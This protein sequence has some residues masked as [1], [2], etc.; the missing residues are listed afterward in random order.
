MQLVFRVKYD[1][2]GEVK[3]FK[4]RV[5]AQGFSQSNGVDYEEIYSPLHSYH[6]STP[7]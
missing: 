1:G 7:Y 4:G 6:P 3:C 5:V 2:N